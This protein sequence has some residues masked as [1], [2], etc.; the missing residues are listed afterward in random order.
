VILLLMG[1]AGAGVLACALF[2]SEE[3]IKITFC[4]NKA[5]SFN[6]YGRQALRLKVDFV[7]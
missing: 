3:Q 7:L 2:A 5:S 1:F 6:V 4:S